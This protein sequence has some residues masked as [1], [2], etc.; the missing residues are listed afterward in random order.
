[1]TAH[2]RW[3]FDDPRVPPAE[4]AGKGIPIAMR[5]ST[6]LDG[7]LSPRTGLLSRSGQVEIHDRVTT[8]RVILLVTRVSDNDAHCALNSCAHPRPA[9]HRSGFT[10]ATDP[11]AD[12]GKTRWR[13]WTDHTRRLR[14]TCGPAGDPVDSA[15]TSGVVATV[16]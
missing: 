14:H 3:S 16:A 13:H 2:L 5:P 12:V 9:L 15:I 8:A 1:M 10:C 11:F 4:P 7:S 6:S